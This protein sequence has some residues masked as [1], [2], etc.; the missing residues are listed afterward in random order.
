MNL[1]SKYDEETLKKLQ[2]I[3][4]GILKDFDAL[5]RK[6]GITYFACGGTTIG[7][8]RHHGFIPWDDDIDVGMLRRDY[9]K[10][11]RVASRKPYTDKYTVINAETLPSYP[12]MTTRWC[13][14]GT[15][16]KEKALQHVEGDL[17]IFLDL[18][19]FDNIPD[20]ELL[21][22]LQ[23]WRA[24][25]YGKLLILYWLDEPVLYFGGLRGRIVTAICRYAHVMLRKL[26]VSP[27]FLYRKAKAISWS[28]RK[29]DTKRVNYLH[30]PKPFMSIMNRSDVLPTTRME[31]DGLMI[32]VPGNIKA[33]LKHRFGD[34]Y[35]TLP[36]EEKRHN[37][38]PYE[39]DLGE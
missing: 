13:K 30:D 11:L 39:L 21:M 16:F 4:L 12:L 18:Y 38:P 23:A 24:W 37:H 26:N 36:P 25:V 2:H 7:T 29:K 17:G 14:K 5:C 22:K 10:F 8:V 33:Y 15:R 6:H 20:N 34:D 9:E 32:S 31:Y 28:Y 27:A 1:Y 3:E 19:C 35:M